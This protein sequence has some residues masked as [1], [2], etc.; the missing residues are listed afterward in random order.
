MVKVDKNRDE[1]RR[2]ISL[3][4]LIVGGAAIFPA[5]IRN[6]QM[7]RAGNKDKRPLVI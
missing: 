4:K 7:V 1:V 2:T 3:S 5:A 6:H